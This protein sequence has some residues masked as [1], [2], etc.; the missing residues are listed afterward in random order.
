MPRVA[1]PMD[2]KPCLW[3]GVSMTRKRFNGALECKSNF[4]RR[5]FCS[6]SCSV[7]HQHATPAPSPAASRKRAQ[8]LKEPWCDACGTTSNLDAHHIDQNPMN[9]APENIQT[10]C[11]RCHGFWHGALKRAQ[12]PPGKRMPR[13]FDF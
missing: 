5:K 6:I 12:E 3:C 13:L 1:E 11:G 4:A 7:S 8:L 10:L 2:A 9:N